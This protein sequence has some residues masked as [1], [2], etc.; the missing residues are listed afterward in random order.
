MTL[1]PCIPLE[2]YHITLFTSVFPEVSLSVTPA[3]RLGGISDTPSRHAVSISDHGYVQISA[4]R[5]ASRALVISFA[6]RS[7][8]DIST[9]QRYALY[10][11]YFVPGDP[12]MRSDT[13]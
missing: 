5:S 7:P 8:T 6:M 9:P 10:G 11:V 2:P 12:G 4:S 1:L 13:S 3:L